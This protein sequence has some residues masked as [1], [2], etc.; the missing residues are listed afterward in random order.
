[1]EHDL[2]DQ[3]FP[4]EV[5]ARTGNGVVGVFCD[6]SAIADRQFTPGDESV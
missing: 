2:Q 1:L 5:L 6:F 4:S 3:V